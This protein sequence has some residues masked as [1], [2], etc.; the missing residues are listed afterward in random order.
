MTALAAHAPRPIQL[1]FARMLRDAPT[2]TIGA[3][4]L[5]LMALPMLAAAGLDTRLVAGINPW[6]KPLKFALSLSLYLGTLAYFAYLLPDHMRRARWFRI[7]SIAVMACIAAEMLWIAG[8]AFAGTTSH[9][10]ISSATMGILYGLM[11]VFA[12]TLTS[13]ALVWGIAIWRSNPGPFARLVAASLMLT[14]ALTIPVAGYMAQQTG[15]FVGEAVSDAGGLW[16]MGWSREVGDLRVAHFFA[17]HAM[18]ILP[19][20]YVI[21][22]WSA[23]ARLPCGTGLALCAAFSVLTAA[24]FVQALAGQ[25]FLGWL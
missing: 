23:G 14:F 25:P 22:L 10:N 21:L 18:Q 16:L 12:V 4:L 11:G 20:A 24:T 17:T 8:A 3:L 6:I 5:F 15:H 2:E 7:F 13:A 9:F 1:P 19:V